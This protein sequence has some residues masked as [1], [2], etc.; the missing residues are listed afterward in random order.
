M[1]Q[2]SSRVVHIH[3]QTVRRYFAVVSH[4]DSLAARSRRPIRDHF[5][6]LVAQ[7]RPW[8]RAQ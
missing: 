6:G 4:R 7:I 5:E 2:L 8:Y 3:V 1:D